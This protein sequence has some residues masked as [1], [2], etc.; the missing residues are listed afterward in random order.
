MLLRILLKIR[1]VSCK[2]SDFA[3]VVVM[4]TGGVNMGRCWPS[5]PNQNLCQKKTATTS[6]LLLWIWRHLQQYYIE[7]SLAV[8]LIIGGF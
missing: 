3:K 5:Q 2:F 4:A 8:I 1:Y 7:R 6:Y